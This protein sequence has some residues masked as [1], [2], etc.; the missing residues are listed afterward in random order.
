ML[1]TFDFPLAKFCSLA[2]NKNIQQRLRQALK[3]LSEAEKYLRVSSDSLTWL[4]AALLQ[5]SSDRPFPPSV[6]GSLT[7]TPMALNIR[8]QGLGRSVSTDFGTVEIEPYPSEI[9]GLAAEQPRYGHRRQA[10]KLS[11]PSSSTVE[12]P[13]EINQVMLERESREASAGKSQKAAAHI[14][15]ENRLNVQESLKAEDIQMFEERDSMQLWN[16]VLQELTSRNLKHLL[17]TQGR[18]VSAGVTSGTSISPFYESL[19]ELKNVA[20]RF[21]LYW[22]RFC[23]VFQGHATHIVLFDS[24]TYPHDNLA[25]NC[26]KYIP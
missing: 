11:E 8:G 14:H 15:A 16:R 4:T 25:F 3:I 22:C 26:C 17:L 2:A 7:H 5:C 23:R 24:S 10:S 12:V 13:V 6:V 1:L 20:I 19:F 21:E 18:L 9:A